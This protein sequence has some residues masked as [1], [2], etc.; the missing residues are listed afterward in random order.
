MTKHQQPTPASQTSASIKRVDR[1][2]A[3]P[4]LRGPLAWQ[5]THGNQAVQRMLQRK[6]GAEGTPKG[7]STSWL[8]KKLADML[9]GS[10]E[11]R[12]QGAERGSNAAKAKEMLEG[13]IADYERVSVA[14]GSNTLTGTLYGPKAGYLQDRDMQFTGTAALLLSGSGGS[15]NM[16]MPEIAQAYVE[17]G[18][19]VLMMDYR[20]FGRS[21]GPDKPSEAGVYDDAE[22]MMS[23]LEG[24]GFASNSVLVHGYSLG[25]PIAAELVLRLSKSGK[26]V[27]GLVLDRAM[28][29]AKKA[30]AAHMGGFGLAGEIGKAAIGRFSLKQKVALLPDDVQILFTYAGKTDLLSKEDRK[31]AEATLERRGGDLVT[32][33]KS[34]RAGHED[35]ALMLRQMKAELRKMSQ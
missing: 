1:V 28:V 4:P 26:K 22:A 12:K 5:R 32:I 18:N 20:G 14:S 33:A 10:E 25:G 7:L 11:A 6:G 17:M 27:K 29:S 13:D 24:E 16:Y 23:L 9:F 2:I 15:S 8:S 31:L 19:V 35:H 34:N 3:Q 30:G 21:S